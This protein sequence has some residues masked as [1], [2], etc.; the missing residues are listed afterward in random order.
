MK[1]KAVFFIFLAICFSA[2]AARFNASGLKFETVNTEHFSI[3]YMQNCSHLVDKVGRKLEQLYNIFKDTYGLTLPSKTEIVI[4]DSDNSNG[5][6]LPYTNT[7]TFWTH[8]L[9]FNLRGTHD[10]WED[11]ITHEY[12][13]IVSIS[14]GLK[15][16]PTVPDIRF[17]FFSHPNEK[18]RIEVFHSLSTS[19]LPYWFTEGIA[20]YESKLNGADSWDAHR[21]MILRTL[22]LSNKQL[23]WAHMQVGSGKGDDYEKSYNHGFAMVSYIAEKYGYD[24]IVKILRESTKINILNFDRAIKNVLGISG[25]ELFEEWKLS[26]EKKY[27]QQISELGTQVYGKKINKD[28]FDN[29]WPKFSPDGSKIFFMS[30]GK[31]DYS[32]KILYSYTLSDTVEEKKKIKPAIPISGFYDIHAQSGKICFS[33]AKSA[34]SQLPAHQGGT[35]VLD[36]YTDTLP[37][38]KKSFKPF[39]KTEHQITQKKSVFYSSFS[40]AGD[41]IAYSQR[42]IDRCFLTITDTS[43]KKVQRVFPLQ[44]DSIEIGFIFS[45]DWSPDGKDI[46]FSFIDKNNRKIA[47]YDTTE[48]RCE[49]FCNTV[50]D[51]RDPSFSPDGKYLYFSS[52]RNGIFNIYRYHFETKQTEQVTNVS[53]GAFAPSLSPDGKKLVYAGYEKNG[54]SIYLIDT[55]KTLSVIHPDTILAPF[56]KYPL[57]ADSKAG[58]PQKALRGVPRQLLVMPI[59]FG[60][61]AVTQDDSINKGKTII[62]TGLIFSLI[63]PWTITGMGS[64]LNGYIFLEPSDITRMIRLKK[65]LFYVKNNY[66]LGL[67]GSTQLLPLTLSFDYTMRGIAGRELFYNEVEDKSENTY[68]NAQIQDLNLKVSHYK[69][70]SASRNEMGLHLLGGIDLYDIRLLLDNV[71]TFKYNLNKGYY[72]GTM[73]TFAAQKPEAKSAISPSGIVAKL[74]YYFWDQHALKEENSFSTDDGFLKERY[75]D[76]Q[77]HQITGHTKMGMPSPWYGRHDLHFDIMGTAIKVI[78]QDTP[79]P[80]FLLPAT[81]IPGYS[82]YTRLKKIK[83]I[84]KTPTGNDTARVDYDTALI[85]GNTVIQGELSYRFPLWPKYLIDKKLGFIYL[86]RL[87]G[88]INFGGGAA[89]NKPSDFLKF[90]RED[91]LLSFGLELRL[92]A[93]TFSNLPLALKIRWDNGLDRN[94][95]QGGNRFT[96]GISYDFD[97]WDMVL[98]PNYKSKRI[99]LR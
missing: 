48:K 12:A 45:I 79:I 36:L 28:G 18:N 87:Y 42:S 40:P 67:F 44:S 17:G 84:T 76:Y 29:F 15:L 2:Q 3:S 32:H 16:P 10:W 93:Q 22:I 34:K 99:M 70:G 60:E 41:R 11:V 25:D 53:G 78:K 56:T 85:S 77:Y 24:K 38:D 59:L 49:V 94:A 89:W 54:Y 86:E 20:Q 61:Q 13:H 75:D 9:D 50:F 88:A 14:T 58:A 72:A 96:F 46:A 66:D 19:I 31:N 6:A 55:I 26:L 51:Q 65:G 23:S 8:D 90:Q 1:Y 4:L 73:A 95:P 74:Q 98:M 63:D 39:H 21:D 62:K 82:Y 35:R 83:S 5:W 71:T 69:D 27:K 91:W 81:W 37:P 80:N 43:G 92:E 64:E 33:S 97:N 52:D 57:T 68:Y 7:V 47:I 30:N